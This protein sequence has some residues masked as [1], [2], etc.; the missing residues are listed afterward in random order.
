[1]LKRKSYLLLTL[2]FSIFCFVNLFTFA[3][4]SILLYTP[5]TGLYVSPGDTVKYNVTVIN[6]TDLIQNFSLVLEGLSEDWN[7]VFK[8]LN[9][10]VEKLSVK[11]AK[12]EDNSRNIDLELEVPLKVEKGIHS[13]QLVART[14]TGLKAVLPLQLNVKEK[15]VLETEFTIDQANMEGYSD[16]NFTYQAELK[17]KTAEKQHYSLTASAPRGWDVRFRVSGDY[18]T[19]LTLDSN[20]SQN[21]SIYVKAPVNVAAGTYNIKVRAS[22]GQTAEEI[23][24]ETVIKG[25]YG[26]NLSTPIGLLSTD[27]PIGGEKEIELLVENTGTVT[28]RDISL[29]ATT[30]IDWSVEFEEDEIVKLD[31]GEKINVKATI[32]ASDK[33]I[34]GDYQLVITARTPETSVSRTFR[35]TTKTSIIWGAIGILIIFAVIGV[36]Y[37][38]IR[39]YGRR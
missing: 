22:S 6:E 18:V 20:E 3:A 25:R 12:L 32:K 8:S 33:A 34:A 36:L 5:F 13:F 37:Y 27:I 23:E 26:I 14:D 17:N 38:F 31:S 11:S 29:S 9:R 10:E 35:I 4:D 7:Y 15:G 39:K 30:P 28:L 1:M 16:S 2:I 24:L 19:S 21:I